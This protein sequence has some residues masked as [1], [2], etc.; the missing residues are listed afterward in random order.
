VVGAGVWRSPPPMSLTVVP[1]DSETG[2]GMSLLVVV[3]LPS[4]PSWFPPQA[5]TWPVLVSARL[6]KQPARTSVTLTPDGSVTLTGVV[7]S[8]VVPL[9]SWPRLFKPQASTW[10]ELVS[11]TV[12]KQPARTWVIFVVAGSFTGVGSFLLVTVP[13]PSCPFAPSPQASRAPPAPAWAGCPAARPG[14]TAAPAATAVARNVAGSMA[15]TAPPRCQPPQ[16]RAR[17]RP[18][19]ATSWRNAS[20]HVSLPPAEPSCDC[21]WPGWNGAET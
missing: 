12:W 8:V 1:A 3:P 19:P 9:P 5:S 13:L 7:L 15:T 4:C 14:S 18:L 16:H 2:S 20:P 10:P 21:A 6:W 17:R 11:A